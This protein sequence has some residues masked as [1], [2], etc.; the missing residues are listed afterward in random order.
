MMNVKTW[1]DRSVTAVLVICAVASSGILIRREFLSASEPQEDH[2]AAVRT[3]K[4]VDSLARTGHRL[5]SPKAALTLVEFG[6][7]ECPSCRAFH[8]RIA[9]LQKRY[10]NQLATAFH[11]YPLNYHRFAYPA[12]RAAECAGEQGRFE[13]YHDVLY[14]KQ[15]S[16]GLLSFN[17]LAKRAGVSDSARFGS[18]VTRS[19]S[20]ANITADV[21]FA[22]ANQLP[23]TPAILLDGKLSSK[24]PPSI[25]SIEAALK[26]SGARATASAR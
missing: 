17:A 4:D 2:T 3:I 23:G 22:Q 16:L 15:D 9:Q 7:F 14:E 25:D 24:G 8:T 11:H 21:R 26:R 1:L 12:A 19:D 5:G 10:P 18:C 13:A 20:V 6:D